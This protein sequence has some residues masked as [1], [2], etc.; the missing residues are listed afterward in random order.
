MFILK[1]IGNF[2]KE[3]LGFW[4]LPFIILVIIMAYI[5]IKEPARYNSI[6]QVLQKIK[7]I[8]EF[9]YVSREGVHWVPP[10]DPGAFPWPPLAQFGE[11]LELIGCDRIGGNL[12]TLWRARAPLSRDYT[13]YVHFTK[14]EDSRP[15]F[16]QA[17]HL[18]GRFGEG[19]FRPTTQWQPGEI[20]ADL[21]PLPEKV[22]R[23]ATFSTRV[24]VWVPETGFRLQPQTEQLV[25]DQYGRLEI[26][27]SSAIPKML[28]TNAQWSLFK[29]MAREPQM[30]L[31]AP[32]DWSV[33]K[34]NALARWEGRLEF[35]G[36]DV[37][38]TRNRKKVYVWQVTIWRALMP[39]DRDFLIDILFIHEGKE[40][41]LGHLLG[42]QF[43]NGVHP[44]HTWK[45][46]QIM[47]DAVPIPPELADLSKV[48]VRIRIKDPQ[49]G[50]FLTPDSDL[51][52]VWDGWLTICR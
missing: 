51:L 22:E 46:N 7:T 36:C 11:E 35:L 26:C 40:T 38:I 18:L 34:L 32:F 24:G 52:D 12:V 25:V 6:N 29:E 27:S 4:E 1:K 47:L 14:P 50:R 42:Q 21:T 2:V 9:L 44:T 31:V 41:I 23:E 16:A 20:V 5:Y 17:D 33:V 30:I 3:K 8:Q 45:P 15:F 48:E 49:N 43:L 10:L 37:A 19:R 13:L 39:L 28:D